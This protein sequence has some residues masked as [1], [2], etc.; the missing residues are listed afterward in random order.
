MSMLKIDNKMTKYISDAVFAVKLTQ[1]CNGSVAETERQNFVT[2]YNLP[3]EQFILSSSAPCS[4]EDWR[5]ISELIA[6]NKDV[7]YVY[8]YKDEQFVRLS[9]EIKDRVIKVVDNSVDLQVFSDVH[10]PFADDGSICLL[11]ESVRC[12]C[13]GHPFGDNMDIDVMEA[14]SSLLNSLPATVA[15]YVEVTLGCEIKTPRE[16]L[17]VM[18]P[19]QKCELDH[20][21][22]I[23]KPFE[24]SKF[25]FSLFV[26]DTNLRDSIRRFNTAIHKG[27]GHLSTIDEYCAKD[28]YID[29]PK[30]FMGLL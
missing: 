23:K 28:K 13:A 4:S 3:I 26:N 30:S 2:K 6:E 7:I 22:N 10:I 9:D 21:L 24:Q 16:L 19:V 11:L 5:F 25:I 18:M 29:M 27:Y 20:F 14:M 1:Y 17:E 8:S 15:E 12:Y